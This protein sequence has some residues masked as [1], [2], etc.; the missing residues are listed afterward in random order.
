MS[1]QNTSVCLSL[2]LSLCNNKLC[3]PLMPHLWQCLDNELPATVED[4]IHLYEG[5]CEDCEIN[6]K[7]DSSLPDCP[8][9]NCDNGSGNTAYLQMVNQ[10]CASRC[11]TSACQSN[12]RILKAVHDNCGE[13]SLSLQAELGYHD[14]EGACGPLCNSG[15]QADDAGQLVCAGDGSGVCPPGSFVFLGACA[16][17]AG[18]AMVETRDRGRLALQDV[19]I[20]DFVKVDDKTNRYEPIYGFAHYHPHV[21]VSSY[22]Q[23]TTTTTS[24]SGQQPLLVSSNH[25]LQ[26]ANGAFRPA[27]AIQIGDVLGNGAIVMEKQERVRAKGIYAPYTPSG[28]IVVDGVPASCYVVQDLHGIFG[29]TWTG[30][31][32]AHAFEFPHRVACYY[33]DFGETVCESY[34]ADGI[35]VWK[36][37][38]MRWAATLLNNADDRP[39][40][41]RNLVLCLVIVVLMSF[42]A[43]EL[44]VFQYPAL[45]LIMV[46]G[47]RT[48]L[49]GA[50]LLG[51]TKRIGVWKV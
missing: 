18:T 17:F 37:A 31:W 32:L 40:W 16:C 2:S 44:L 51:Q 49:R 10:N 1:N 21:T 48:V 22:D 39:V 35:H 13:E 50:G 34:N 28:T 4:G 11:G 24:T 3:A 7:Y 23:I 47:A 36:E 26:L 25:L 45:L 6:R 43:V 46:L 15:S 19:A 33:L 14:L 38:P 41:L 12:F 29:V 9:A 42:V 20:G 30:H 8:T 5:S 27:G